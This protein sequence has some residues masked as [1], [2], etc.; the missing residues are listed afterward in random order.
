[1]YR[2][3]YGRDTLTPIGLLAWI[4]WAISLPIQA[5]I[6]PWTPVG[7]EGGVLPLI[8]T[9]PADADV[10]FAAVAGGVV[11]RTTDYGKHWQLQSSPVASDEAYGLARLIADPTNSQGVYLATSRRLLRSADGGAQWQALLPTLT[12]PYLDLSEFAV[13][14]TDS[15]VLYLS[16]IFQDKEHPD[17]YPGILKSTDGGTS[18]SWLSE[19]LDAEVLT[20][21]PRNGDRMFAAGVSWGADTV[22]Q[23][24]FRSTDR[25][26]SWTQIVDVSPVYIIDDHGVRS[27]AIDT[28]SPTTLFATVGFHLYKSTDDGETWTR[29]STDSPSDEDNKPYIVQLVRTA[30]SDPGAV[31][32]LGAANYGSGLLRSEDGGETWRY[33][34]DVRGRPI[35]QQAVAFSIDPKDARRI[36]IGSLDG[37]LVTQDGGTSWSHS[38]SGIRAQVA[39]AHALYPQDSA[40]QYLTV[41]GLNLTRMYRSADHGRTWLI[42]PM[43]G[44]VYA[45]DR[46]LVDTQD[47]DLLFGTQWDSVFRSTD[48]GETAEILVEN[49]LPVESQWDTP[50]PWPE[51]LELR[52]LAAT[53]HD[54]GRLYAGG[55]GGVLASADGGDTWYPANAG[56]DGYS[57]IVS[58]AADP[59][60]PLL[61]YAGNDLHPDDPSPIGLFRSRDGG[62]SWQATGEIAGVPLQGTISHLSIDRFNPALLYAKSDPHGVI[63]SWDQGE[64]WEVLGSAPAGPKALSVDPHN[65]RRLYVAAKEGVFASVDAGTIWHPLDAGY[66]MLGAVSVAQDTGLV[67]ATGSNGLVRLANAL[68]V[69]AGDIDGDGRDEFAL[70]SLQTNGSIPQI[71]YFDDDGRLLRT[72]VLEQSAMRFDLAAGDFDG[73]GRADWALAMIDGDGNLAVALYDGD[74]SL[75][76]GG[77]GGRCTAVSVRSAQLDADPEDEYLVGLIQSD[78]R[79]AAIAFNPDGTRLGKLLTE[80]GFQAE[81]DVVDFDGDPTSIEVVL[82]YRALDS[83]LRTEV[84]DAAGNRLGVGSGGQ[85][86]D[87]KLT[88]AHPAEGAGGDYAVSLIQSDG[89]LGAIAFSAQGSRHWKGVGGATFAPQLAAGHFLATAPYQGVV[90]SLIQADGRPAAIFLGEGGIRLAKGVAAAPGLVAD[91]ATGD[92]DGNGVSEAIVGYLDTDGN[93]RWSVFTENGSEI[94]SR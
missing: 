10:L 18:W 86:T 70:A 23:G 50:E 25:G 85:C 73:N 13:D 71:E 46:I 30:L 64:H 81:A 4:L 63:R 61:L 66:W 40:L 84:F 27:I 19:G 75:I 21:D 26:R 47:P 49:F 15:R 1:M 77:S 31:Y 16:G 5:G 36:A 48:G 80:A 53:P 93:T 76:G 29:L 22:L 88:V 44:E 94:R 54:G 38:R 59:L 33:L 6:E 17:G 51:E 91:V 74:G 11:F 8:D 7:P 83:T 78:R 82:A 89:S 12:I 45:P 60:D 79:A 35:D 55:G 28:K 32:V 57:R 72:L 2:S 92:L 9:S 87:V 62:D 69:A 34:Y 14:P 58:L 90:V 43:G 41:I 56:M 20:I 39:G 68:R 52:A 67:Y 37:S 42:R 65:P 3:K 24:I